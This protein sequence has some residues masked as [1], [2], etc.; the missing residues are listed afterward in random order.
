[1]PLFSR[2][3]GID[4]GTMNIVVTEG[5]QILLHEPTVVAI[6]VNELKMVE[7]GQAAKDMDGRV[8][9]SIEVIRPMRHGVIAEYEI[10][11]RLLRFLIKKLVGPMLIFR[12][13]AMMT[14]PYG[15]TSVESRAVHEAGLNGAATRYFS[16][17]SHWLLQLVSTC[18]SKLHRKLI[19]LM[20]GGTNRQRFW[21]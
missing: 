12:P 21:Q 3:M 19:I 20:G 18:P 16:S 13:K 14:V 6:V 15:I 5:N 8:P 11:E 7:W 1:M 2:E 4:L 10:I 17:S 9:D